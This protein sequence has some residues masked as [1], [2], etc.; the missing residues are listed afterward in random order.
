[1]IYYK[2]IF[3]IPTLMFLGAAGLFSHLRDLT[4]LND[5]KTLREN[6]AIETT[7]ISDSFITYSP[8]FALSDKLNYLKYADFG[9]TV[10]NSLIENSE[11]N[12]KISSID[13]T[14]D[15]DGDG[16]PDHLDLDDDN[17]GILDANECTTLSGQLMFWNNNS[18]STAAGT[19]SVVSGGLLTG[20]NSIAGSGLTRTMETTNHY[21]VISGVAATSENAAITAN[22]YIQYTV[23]VGDKHIIIDRIGYYSILT[24]WDNTTY[25]YSLKVSDDNFAT[26]TQVHG[27]KAYT[28]NGGDLF[29]NTNQPLYLEPN[30]TYTFRVYFYS[31][32]GGTSANFGHDDFKLF[33]IVECD[34]DNDG[35]PNRLD[36]DSDNDGCPDVIEGAAN[37]QVG[38]SYITG[39][40]LNTTVNASGVRAVPAGTTGYAV[41]TGQ[42]VGQSQI[43]N[44]AAVGGAASANQTIAPNTAPTAL[45]L[46]GSTG[47][48]QWQVSTDNVTFNNVASGGTTAS[49][50]PG[51]L[52]ATRYYRVLLTSVGGCTATSNV[53]TITVCAAGSV[54][55]NFNNFGTSR[56]SYFYDYDKNDN[57]ASFSI[58]CGGGITADLT[59][60]TLKTGTLATPLPA[61]A[62]LTWHSATPATD[63]NQIIDPLTA[64]QGATRKIYAAFRGGANCYSPTR[65]ISIYAPICAN[66][67]DYTATPVTYG[68]QHTFP[69]VFVNDTYN[70]IAI[71]SLPPD[72]VGLNYS[73]WVPANA[74]ID[75]STGVITV[76]PDVLPGLYSYSYRIVDKD[77]DGVT[78]SNASYASVF[79]RVIAD[80][81]GDG[82]HDEADMDDDNDGILDTVEGFCQTQTIYSMD[83][84]ATLASANASFNANGGSF[85]LVYTL[86]SG[87]AVA[88]IGA[89]FNVPFYYS[90]FTNNASLV[91]HRWEGADTSATR[92]GI[93]PLT[94]QLYTGLPVNNSTSE[95]FNTAQ[96][97]DWNF[98]N[99]LSTGAI[100]QLG[101]FTTT[102]GSLPTP[103]NQLSTYSNRPTIV[104]YST[105]N[106]H[107]VAVPTGGYYANMQ[108]QT[109]PEPGNY[110]SSL[111]YNASYGRSY[112]WNY[113]AFNGNAA[114]NTP[115]NAGNR[116]LITINRNS[117]TFCNHRDTDGDLTPD[118]LD[119]DSDGDGC[120]DALEGDE[121]IVASQLRIYDDINVA[122]T[123]GIGTTP[124]VN[125][126]VPNLVNSGGAADIGGDVGQGIGASQNTTLNLCCMNLPT[127]GTPDGYTQTGISSIP[128]FN[129]T[130]TGWPQNVPNGFVAIESKNQGFVITRVANTAAI[131]TPVEGMLIYDISVSCVKLYNG[132]SWKCLEKD[133]N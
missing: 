108:I 38:A 92:L 67:D 57:I 133:C 45:S 63:A 72:S 52:S 87:T 11:A 120:V 31:V 74:D 4:S 129:T 118:Y 12:H 101:T 99:W 80:I 51:T 36:L 110:T 75:F 27:T 53:V 121:N 24:S 43:V 46:T 105:W 68:V 91:D 54:A 50:S 112:V 42:A 61:G 125:N 35:I 90:D 26:S 44:P 104:L 84:A 65:E 111:D 130:G 17:D 40:R 7:K 117:I 73:V 47:T 3:I 77:T 23:N 94:S 79:F 83:M 30:T 103:S 13:L 123:G 85:N 97:P 29:Y 78:D 59:L 41:A 132:T 86:A 95:A 34:T 70:N 127:A 49:Y 116:G 25:S 76:P 115:G 6:G 81:D 64:V 37:F 21:Q 20:N 22:E 66:D 48:I 96:S 122:A 2:Q 114:S 93:R 15:S 126:G 128:G 58:K 19:N 69:S 119:L 98:K 8:T 10:V 28:T 60:L 5:S 131:A 88:G 102:I 107:D 106:L 109:T 124:N 14:T 32:N 33:G 9:K 100:D 89:T 62:T 16:V 18:G 82:I 55:P 39:N 56:Y 1:M 113:T 71:S